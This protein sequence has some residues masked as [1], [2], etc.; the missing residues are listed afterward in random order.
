[1]SSIR[2]TISWAL[3]D[4][5]LELFR[6]NLEAGYDFDEATIEDYDRFQ[7]SVAHA[8]VRK[9]FNERKKDV[10]RFLEKRKDG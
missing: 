5:L 4:T 9:Q 2:V 1:M 6:D 3:A 10:R 8:K 7:D